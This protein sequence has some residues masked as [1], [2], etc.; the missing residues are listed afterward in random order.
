MGVLAQASFIDGETLTEAVLNVNPNFLTAWSTNIDNTNIG[1]AGLF[2]TQIKPTTGAQA[3]FGGSVNYTF[4]AAI[5]AT[6][7]GNSGAVSPNFTQ[8]GGG[9]AATQHMVYG[10]TTVAIPNGQPSAA[11]NV[12][13]SGAAVFTSTATY[14]VVA[15]VNGNGLVQT[16]TSVNTPAVISVLPLAGTS[17]SITAVTGNGTNNTGSTATLTIFWIA[18]GT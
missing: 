4:P 17:F 13:L 6:T 18:T 10:T 2:A 14:G 12:T 9:P 1:G 16:A 8:T 3:V 11:V 15:I 5:L 7:G